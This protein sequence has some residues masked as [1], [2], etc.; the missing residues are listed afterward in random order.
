MLATLCIANSAKC[1][2]TLP[3]EVMGTSQTNVSI[4]L[5]VDASSLPCDTL[6]LTVHGLEWPGEASIQVNNSNWIPLNNSTVTI[7]GPGYAGNFGGIG[8]PVSLFNLQVPLPAGTVQAGA[9]Q[10]NFQLNADSANNCGY[11]VLSVNFLGSN[12]P[13]VSSDQ[14]VWDDPALWQP[15]LNDPTDIAAGQHLWQNATLTF[16]PLS[17]K[18]M[19]A[20]CSDCHTDDGRDLSYF[21]YSNNSIITRSEFHGLTQLQGEQ[22]ASYIRSLPYASVNGRPWNPPFQPGPGLDSNGPYEWSAGAGI[23]AVLNNDEAMIP[24]LFP[25]GMTASVHDRMNVREIPITYP[26]MDWNHWLPTEA[27]EDIWYSASAYTLR[28]VNPYSPLAGSNGHFEKSDLYI[29]YQQLLQNL[30]QVSGNPAA[31]MSYLTGSFRSDLDVMMDNRWAIPRGKPAQVYNFALWRT[32]KQWGM[33]EQFGLNTLAPQVSLARGGLPGNVQ[34]VEW[35]GGV[36]FTNSPARLK[37]ENKTNSAVTGSVLGDGYIETNWYLAQLI[38]NPGDGISPGFTIIDWG[39]MP[40]PQ[41]WTA[42]HGLFPAEM[43]I[44]EMVMKSMQLHDA[45]TLYEG[46]V[47]THFNTWHPSWAGSAG[48]LLFYFPRMIPEAGL[49]DVVNAVTLAWLEKNEE[50]TPS[51]WKANPITVS[52]TIGLIH[53][54]LKNNIQAGSGDYLSASTLAAVKSWVKSVWPKISW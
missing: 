7:T 38:L 27:P 4:S 23:D 10:V 14:F 2:V 11:R 43:M 33:Q 26:M 22:I 40:G 13:A 31:L 34:A 51:Q 25:N 47:G 29:A 12:E 3:I 15:P 21:N 17:T 45:P 37:V 24:Y 50:F 8:G 41:T 6:T 53:Y 16:N 20:H 32:V 30:N 54:V 1:Q 52:T 36:P 28:G 5:N 35:F 19:K 9:N 44:A 42:F 18:T 49:N 46:N 48:T 39:Y